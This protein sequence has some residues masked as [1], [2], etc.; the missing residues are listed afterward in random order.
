MAVIAMMIP[1]VAADAG[2]KRSDVSAHGAPDRL[3]VRRRIRR[4]RRGQDG[5]LSECSGGQQCAGG[6][7]DTSAAIQAN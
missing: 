3:D 2:A 5:G 4:R 6:E 1:V 7:R